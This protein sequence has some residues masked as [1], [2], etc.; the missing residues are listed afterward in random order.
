MYCQ[1]SFC[2]VTVIF[3]DS[4][5]THMDVSNYFPPI[6]GDMPVTIPVVLILIVSPDES[7]G[8]LGFSTVMP[9]P[10]P[11]QRFPFRHDNLKIFQLDL[12]NLVCGFIW[13]MT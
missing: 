12:S 11:P 5:T 10:P 8:Y 7:R 9:P 2:K 1:T 3:P 6:I 4:V 13:A